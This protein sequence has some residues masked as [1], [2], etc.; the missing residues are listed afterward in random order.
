MTVQEMKAYQTKSNAK[1]EA[2]VPRPTPRAYKMVGLDDKV[3]V[4]LFGGL[5]TGKTKFLEGP[6]ESG[7]RVLVMSTDFG[8]NGLLTVKNSLRRKGKADLL[9]AG[10]LNIDLGE[11]KDVVG[12]LDNPL[13]YI[14][15]ILTFHPTV[16]AWDGFSTFNNDYLDE[17]SESGGKNVRSLAEDKFGHWYDVK[18]ATLRVLRKFFQFVR[19]DGGNLYKILTTIEA[20]PDVNEYTNVTERAPLIQ[21]G[22]KEFTGGGF[23]LVMQCFKEDKDGKERFY[24]RT[25]GAKFATKNRDF[26]LKPVED[27]D[28]VRIWQVLTGK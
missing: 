22:A 20:K 3:K 8:N 6:I 11:Y 27:A 14:P 26:D 7:E 9:E 18:R 17:E 10:L 15:D 2:A 28:P 13:G 1:V 4:L 19:P 21:G 12:F 16:L 25:A 24:Y 23:D 5:G